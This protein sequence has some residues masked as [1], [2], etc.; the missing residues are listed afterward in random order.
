M[1]PQ[2]G[3]LGVTHSG[4]ARNVKIF[5]RNSI[6]N[7]LGA[8][9]RVRAQYQSVFFFLAKLVCCEDAFLK[10]KWCTCKL[11]SDNQLHVDSPGFWS[12]V[13]VH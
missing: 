11:Q 13:S 5:L 2:T 1:K 9:A 4:T 10:K 6:F 3:Q 12:E 7:I 8:L